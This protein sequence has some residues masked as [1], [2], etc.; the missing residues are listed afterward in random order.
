MVNKNKVYVKFGIVILDDF[1]CNNNLLSLINY[2]VTKLGIKLKYELPEIILW[3]NP[4][5][6]HKSEVK[7][8]VD[9]IDIANKLKGFGCTHLVILDNLSYSTI[10]EIEQS[11]D[12]KIINLLQEITEVIFNNYPELERVGIISKK[13]KCGNQLLDQWLKKHL[14]NVSM[15]YLDNNL[16]DT[17]D[18][19][20]VKDNNY[21]NNFY[22]DLCSFFIN[23]EISIVVI[24]FVNI[25]KQSLIEKNINF[26]D[27]LDVVAN[28]LIK[29]WILE[30]N[31]PRNHSCYPKESKSW[32]K[33]IKLDKKD[34]KN[35]WDSRG[36]V[37]T[38]N[39]RDVD[40]LMS[41]MISNEPSYVQKFNNYEINL[42][43]PLLN[44]DAQS[45]TIL[46]LGCGMARWLVA[47]KNN[48]LKYTGIDGN[49]SYITALKNRY[50]DNTRYQ[51]NLVFFEEHTRFSDISVNIE[52]KYSLV[53]INGLF[54]YLSDSITD[55]IFALLNSLLDTKSQIYIRESVSVFHDRLTLSNHYS[56]ALNQHYSAIYRTPR[57]YYEYIKKYILPY[58]FKITNSGFLHNDY[59]FLETNKKY[60]ILQR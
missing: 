27:M 3:Q 7:D 48:I 5:L 45:S 32:G 54:V 10:K 21:D 28:S 43:K 41:V 60:F 39:E 11:V 42:I 8:R 51:F 22:N 49:S 15:V 50:N 55:N 13:D 24:W 40:E 59:K 23:R 53:I 26:I 47:L 2:K 46:D 25:C 56:E 57:N 18:N 6:V 31:F 37:I 52:S 34:V 4:K 30:N 19:I 9:Y 33:A 1:F 14:P 12:I 38:N 20:M 16:Q 58:G 44:L 36:T 29:I 17:I 35:T